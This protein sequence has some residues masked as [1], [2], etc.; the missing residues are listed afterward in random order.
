[1]LPG[2]DPAKWSTAP[3]PLVVVRLRILWREDDRVAPCRVGAEI[4]SRAV[5]EQPHRVMRTLA[6]GFGELGAAEVELASITTT[7]TS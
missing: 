5:V 2:P 3:K 7:S 4:A 1:M 6:R